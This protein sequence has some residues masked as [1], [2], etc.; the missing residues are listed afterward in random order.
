MGVAARKFPVFAMTKIDNVWIAVATLIHPDTLAPTRIQGTIDAVFRGAL[1]QRK[2]IP[3]ALVN[4]KS[5]ATFDS[6]DVVTRPERRPARPFSHVLAQ[7]LIAS[8]GLARSVFRLQPLVKGGA[9]PFEGGAVRAH[10]LFAS[11]TLSGEPSPFRLSRVSAHA[12]A[13]VV[14]VY[15]I[16]SGAGGEVDRNEAKRMLEAARQHVGDDVF[17]PWD[18]EEVDQRTF[19]EQYLW[20]IYVSGFRN[21]V[22]EKHIAALTAAFHNL[23]LD[24]IV[25]MKAIDATTLP[26]RNQRKA[27]AFVKGC[28]LIHNEG[29]EDFK[30]RLRERGRTALME[31][32]FMGPATSQHMALALGIEDTEKADTWIRKC[33]EEC[34]A[35]VDQ[36]VTFLSR[37]FELTRQQVD[38]YL[39]QYCRDNQRL[40]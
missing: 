20:V 23:D 39:W 24:R 7:R 36:L 34:S 17:V 26:I 12:G 16:D 30:E 10:A 25:A 18:F 13:T 5:S 4:P 2:Y 19:V 3:H 22:V 40:P 11:A 33:A 29:W 15:G 38:A 1:I 21:A 9:W 8:L 27:E 37:E 31:L 35:T 32:P 6:R 14:L 28:T